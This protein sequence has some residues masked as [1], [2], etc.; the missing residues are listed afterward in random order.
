MSSAYALCSQVRPSEMPIY[1][2]RR[3]TF[4]PTVKHIT[5][6][7]AILFINTLQSKALGFDRF[8]IAF[9]MHIPTHIVGQRYPMHSQLLYA[10]IMRATLQRTHVATGVRRIRVF[11]NIG[12]RNEKHV[13]TLI[14]PM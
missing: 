13:R 8:A 5:A 10:R 4:A 7:L 11:T 9:R 6:I 3:V 12:S 1:F 2:K 14:W